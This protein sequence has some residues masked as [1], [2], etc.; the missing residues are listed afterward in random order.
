M[1]RK[2]GTSRWQ[3]ELKREYFG[4]GYNISQVRNVTAHFEISRNWEQDSH[5]EENE[6]VA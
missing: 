6:P 1:K 3:E 4:K 2:W 5:S